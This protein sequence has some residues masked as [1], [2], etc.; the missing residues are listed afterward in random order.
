MGRDGSRRGLSG[1]LLDV[2]SPKNVP[3]SAWR[4]R[5]SASR[6]GSTRW[7]NEASEANSYIPGAIRPVLLFTKGR[8][9]E[10]SGRRG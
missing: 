5:S 1:S 3:K 2:R 9:T 6:G 4:R 10:M 8:I 7:R